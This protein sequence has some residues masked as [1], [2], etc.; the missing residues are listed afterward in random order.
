MEKN[1]DLRMLLGA[2][3]KKLALILACVI[4]VGAL[5]FSYS[6][7]FI[8]DTYKTS[9]SVLVHNAQNINSNTSTI[10]DIT[11]ADRLT[12]Q[13][14]EILQNPAILK[15]VAA[16]VPTD[17]LTGAARVTSAQ[18]A[19]MVSFSSSGNAIIK[20]NVTSTDPALCIDVADAMANRGGELLREKVEASSVQR[21]ESTKEDIPAPRLV[22]K[23]IFRNTIIGCIIGFVL[24][25]FPI[26]LFFYFD[27]TVKAS[28]DITTIHNVPV[29]GEV[30]S[31]DITD[32]K[33]AKGGRRNG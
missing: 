10:S 14:I 19:G 30:P 4:L 31:L 32:N 13:F 9:V 16:A 17:P 23:G 24:A 5:F 26:I 20:I 6:A 18:L 27:D 29:L 1:I 12:S 25:A 28:E 33:R 7:F 21:I 15:H 8:P 11:A 3:H 22:S 2:L